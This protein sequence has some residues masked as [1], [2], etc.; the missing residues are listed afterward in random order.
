MEY[1]WFK[2]GE[3]SGL[4]S[5]WCNGTKKGENKILDMMHNDPRDRVKKRS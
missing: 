4:G 2:R 3:L 1:K 5:G